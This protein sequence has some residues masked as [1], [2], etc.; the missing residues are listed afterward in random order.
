MKRLVSLLS[1]VVLLVVAGGLAS[2]CDATPP[3]ASVN[4]ATIAT[5]TLNDQLHAY[6]TTQAGA[7]LLTIE[8]AGSAVQVQG[9]GGSGTYDMNFVDG[10][11]HQGVS[12]ILYEQYAAAHDV[13]VTPAQVATAKSE[14]ESFL[15]GSISTQLSQANAVGQQSFCQL[16]NGQPVTGAQVLAGLPASLRSAQI[17]SQ[18]IEDRLLALGDNITAADIFAYYVKNPTQFTGACVSAIESDSQAHANALV[19]QINGGAS[20]ASVAKANSL[21]QNSA[22][23]GGALGCNFTVASVEQ[24]LQVPSLTVGALVGPVQESS[25]GAWVIFEVTGEVTQS[26]ADATPTIRQDLLRSNANQT[27]VANQVKRFARHSA[28]SVDPRYGTWTVA[29]IVP[30][31][32]P[33]PIDLLAAALSSGTKSGTKSSGSGSSS[34]G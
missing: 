5:G 17:Q 2:A 27:R 11:L 20:F 22:P 26:L 6:E 9:Q 31:P 4:G 33:K 34:T 24:E 28:I 14:V 8:S 23:N 12:N 19:A 18:A 1:V 21:D 30:P 32:G 10:I 13:Q 16:Q 29:R 25:T 7:C 3:A 15:D